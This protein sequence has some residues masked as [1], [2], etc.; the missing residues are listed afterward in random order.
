ME[1]IDL[2]RDNLPKSSD[3]VLARIEEMR[4]HELSND[5][6]FDVGAE[7]VRRYVYLLVR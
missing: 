4:G 3:R 6:R 7:R 5:Q 2:I 1:S